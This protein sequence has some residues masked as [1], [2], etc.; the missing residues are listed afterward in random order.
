M[1]PVPSD[2][3]ISKRF[4]IVLGVLG[5]LIAGG[6]LWMAFAV[7]R[8]PDPFHNQEGWSRE[9][10]APEQ[11]SPTLPLDP[12]E[13]VPTPPPPVTPKAAAPASQST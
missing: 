3:E 4:T 5:V 6:L 2:D 13:N 8:K 7:D 12:R 10:P 9:R 11:L 1:S